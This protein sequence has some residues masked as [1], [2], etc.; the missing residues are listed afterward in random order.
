MKRRIRRGRAAGGVSRFA[1][2]RARSEGA[3]IFDASR[4]KVYRPDVRG[5]QSAEVHADGSLGS[6]GW[7]DP[8]SGEPIDRALR[9]AA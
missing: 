6:W 7:G 1:L 2:L 3:A 8:I 4:S 9:R 5:W